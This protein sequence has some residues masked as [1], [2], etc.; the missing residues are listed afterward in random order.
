MDP[1]FVITTAGLAAASVADPEGPH[2]HITQFKIGTGYNYTPD[3]SD[4]VLHGSVLYEGAP[5]SFTFYSDDTTMFVC[6]IP[7]TA[8]PFDYGEIG[9][10]LDDGTLF[11]LAAYPTKRSK[12]NVSVSGQ[13]HLV[14]INC[15]IKLEQSPAIFNV[16]TT[17]Q[18]TLLEASTFATVT[19]PQYAPDGVNAV[20][21]NHSTHRALLTRVS[22]TEWNPVGWTHLA[23]CEVSAVPSTTQITS[24]D[25]YRY[26]GQTSG[27]TKLLL[28]DS[29]GNVRIVTAISGAGT[30]ATLS[31][32]I[33]T[34][35]GI[36]TICKLYAYF[37]KPLDFLALESEAQNLWTDFNSVWNNGGVL[38]LGDYGEGPG[39][40]SGPAWTPISAGAAHYGWGQTSLD[41]P[42]AYDEPTR[43]QWLELQAAV[44]K[45]SNLVGYMADQDLEG[46]FEIPTDTVSPYK[47][48]RQ[49]SRYQEAVN[50]IR[51]RRFRAVKNALEY[52]L[53]GGR[54]KTFS[55]AAPWEKLNYD[56]TYTF[57]NENAMRAFFTSGGYMEFTVRSSRSSYI[58]WMAYRMFSQLGPIRFK[59]DGV[60]SMGPLRIKCR[61]G[62][63]SILSNGPLGFVGLT[64]T[65]KRMFSYMMP[66]SG[67]EETGVGVGG[68]GRG[69]EMMMVELYA[70]RDAS[71]TYILKLEFYV[72]QT[73]LDSTGVGSPTNPPFIVADSDPIN[74]ARITMT[75]DPDSAL[76]GSSTMSSV[77]ATF[78][79]QR[80]NVYS[81]YGRPKAA[82]LTIPYPTVALAGST[83]WGVDNTN[84]ATEGLVWA[85]ATSSVETY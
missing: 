56:L 39:T 77:S 3:V 65:R 53:I 38:T 55:A 24:E 49:F 68:Y 19:P 27:T 11:A 16:T 23:D 30:I 79:G 12:L 75:D 33:S 57:T 44:I 71:T 80:I 35:G 1:Q 83:S 9:L 51:K 17:S 10:F 40:Y 5:T 21:V 74:A 6:E 8:G 26:M 4:T 59:Y 25:F 18:M 46:Y 64:T 20:I 22:D 32:A 60:E 85:G 73:L 37:D 43:D 81:V 78:T 48:F 41:I 76:G 61:Y 31:E 72:Y 58:E 84:A 82:L 29:L 13:P 70:T 34:T 45:A 63:G 14:R 2:I 28:Q 36:G 54:T 50:H 15:L 66:L 42:G 69:D 47:R 67:K 62:D 7:T 52:A